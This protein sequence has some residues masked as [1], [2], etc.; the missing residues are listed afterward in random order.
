V[1]AP[2][3]EQRFALLTK[4]HFQLTQKPSLFLTTQDD[5][6]NLDDNNNA[7]NEYTYTTFRSYYG[8]PLFLLNR[9]SSLIALASGIL[10]IGIGYVRLRDYIVGNCRT[11]G[12]IED[13]D[14]YPKR[15][16]YQEY[17]EFQS[18]GEPRFM[19]NSITTPLEAAKNIVSR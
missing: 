7:N 2:I 19:G 6:N 14:Y 17:G 9:L 3:N 16:G 1:V 11:R 10:L 12:D 18:D 5:N 13:N 8:T 4:Y 15:E